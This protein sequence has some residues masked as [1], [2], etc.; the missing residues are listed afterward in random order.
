MLLKRRRS[1]QARFRHGRP[2]HVRAPCPHA[3]VA[4][5]ARYHMRVGADGVGLLAWLAFASRCFPQPDPRLAP[6]RIYEWTLFS[7]G[8]RRVSA[9]HPRSSLPHDSHDEAPSVDDGCCS[10]SSS[11]GARVPAGVR[12]PEALHQELSSFRQSAGTMARTLPYA[13]RVLLAG[14]HGSRDRMAPA[15]CVSVGHALSVGAWLGGRVFSG[16]W[17]FVLVAHRAIF[18]ECDEVDA[19]VHGFIPLPCHVAL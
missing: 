4:A 19:V 6:R 18:A 13:S 2:S 10:A 5:P 15:G 16:G 17:A 1:A 7:V 9:R 11:G 3:V 14:R 8:C 12:A